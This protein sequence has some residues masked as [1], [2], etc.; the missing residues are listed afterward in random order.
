[1]RRVFIASALDIQLKHSLVPLADV[2]SG[3]DGGT[4]T[5]CE[6]IRWQELGG[7][8]TF[9]IPFHGSSFSQF[10]SAPFFRLALQPQLV[11][12]GQLLAQS[13]Q[14][15]SGMTGRGCSRWASP[16]CHWLFAPGCSWPWWA[17]PP[18]EIAPQPCTARGAAHQ[19]RCCFVPDPRLCTHALAGAP[20]AQQLNCLVAGSRLLRTVCYEHEDTSSA[21]YSL[22][23]HYTLE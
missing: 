7:T 11:R 4:G 8:I 14:Q 18:A 3:V 1:M 23:S 20:P 2:P 19:R 12:L 21:T 10:P 16:H 13:E 9:F 22:L 17:A 5:T 6:L 15:N